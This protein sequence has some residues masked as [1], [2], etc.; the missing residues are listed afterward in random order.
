MIVSYYNNLTERIKHFSTAI[1]FSTQIKQNQS[2]NRLCNYCFLL[3]KVWNLLPYLLKM[4]KQIWA[5]PTYVQRINFY[6][7]SLRYCC[8]LY[9]QWVR[10]ENYKNK[11]TNQTKI[12]STINTQ[13]LKVIITIIQLN[14]V[15]IKNLTGFLLSTFKRTNRTVYHIKFTYLPRCRN[16]VT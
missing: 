9:S 15:K 5:S 7:I 16:M 14:T 6:H 1:Y 11:L 13:E 10:S 3:T 12:Q 2:N 4:P 8:M